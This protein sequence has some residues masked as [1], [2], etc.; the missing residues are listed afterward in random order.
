MRRLSLAVVLLITATVC[1]EQEV[2]IV[3]WNVKDLMSVSDVNDRKADLKSLAQATRP[4]IL[5]LQEITSLA[6]AKEIRDAMELSSYHVACSDFVQSDGANRSAFEV[7]LVSRF[8]FT[9]VI[10]Y[11]PS[12]DNRDYEDDPQEITLAPVL[13]LGIQDVNTSRG[14]L[15]ARIASLKLTVAVVHL[16]SSRGRMGN[17]DR[18]NAEKRELVAAAVAA[19]VNEDDSY[20]PDYSF[21]VLGD[22]NVGHSDTKKNGTALDSDCYANCGNQDRYDET[23]ALLGGG[24]VG[25][26]KMK[27]LVLAI[28]DSTYPSF[29]G[30]PID[31]IY[32]A[33]AFKDKFSDAQKAS[34]TF[35]SDH[36]P[37]W[38]V[39]TTP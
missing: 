5:C 24:L 20:F 34:D 9:Q 10:E 13:Q 25:G 39:L 15:W 21:I 19:G 12:A 23:H 33:G 38:T 6:I 7:A 8:P 17:S 36:L 35:G 30:S 14:Y 4:D 29:P 18:K 2:R 37:V 31:N 11:D 3:T 22:F 16:K 32:V 1:A 28:T 26:L 27:N